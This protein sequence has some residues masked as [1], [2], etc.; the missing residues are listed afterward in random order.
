VYI[1]QAYEDKYPG[2][3][4]WYGVEFNRK[5]AWF[6]HID[7]FTDKRRTRRETDVP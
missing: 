5:N 1:E 6:P 3:E 4:S 7:L 2:V